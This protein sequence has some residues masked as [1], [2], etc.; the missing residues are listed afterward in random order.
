LDK[1]RHAWES[2]EFGRPYGDLFFDRATGKLPEM[3]SSKA[4]VKRLSSILRPGDHLLDVGCGAGHYYRSLKDRIAMPIRYTGV[5][6]TP[7]YIERASEAFREDG[8]ATF[9]T[10]DI[11]DLDFAATSF[12]VVMCNNVLLHLPSIV[13]P[14]AEL[15]RVARRH[16]LIRT[17]VASKSYVVMDVTPRPDGEDFDADGAPR[18]FHYLNIYGEGYVRHLLGK[19]RRVRG[20]RIEPDRDFSAERVGDTGKALAEAWDA[21]TVIEGIQRTGPIL[22]NWCWIDIE[23]GDAL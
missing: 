3:E 10:G 22:L 9:L 11:F 14:L 4:A 21:T 20:V 19:D 7:Y 8:A 23:L 18:D 2:E 6:A 17:V 16:I 12:D 13:R 15:C 5:D 1:W